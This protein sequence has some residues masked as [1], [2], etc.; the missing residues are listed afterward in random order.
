MSA[1][2][3]N[4]NFAQVI[5]AWMDD[6]KADNSIDLNTVFKKEVDDSDKIQLFSDK[7]RR[8]MLEEFVN[9][10]QRHPNKEKVRS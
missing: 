4:V 1:I 3:T 2:I 10:K 5:T 6:D 9:E 8:N 7:I